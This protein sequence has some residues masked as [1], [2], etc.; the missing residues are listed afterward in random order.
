MQ[1]M[2]LVY[3]SINKYAPRTPLMAPA[4]ST[5]GTNRESYPPTSID[6]TQNSNANIPNNK[7]RARYLCAQ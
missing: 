4:A 5:A 6:A 3:G 1:T 2:S 7:C